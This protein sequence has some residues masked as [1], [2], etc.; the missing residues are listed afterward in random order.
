MGVLWP[1]SNHMEFDNNGV[2]ASGAKAYFYEAE[3]TTPKAVY[4]DGDETTPHE[5][6]LEADG[7][8]RWPA[9]YVPYGSY[10]VA[11]TTSGGT[12]IGST[13]DNIPNPE[14]FDESFEVDET[15]QLNTGDTWWSPLDS[16]RTGAVRLNGRTMGSASSGGTERAHADT[17]DLFTFL[18]NALANGQAAVSGGRGASAAAD[19]AANKTITLPDLRGAL[20]IGLTDMG[21]TD[22]GGLASAPVT[23]GAATTPGSVLGANTHALT[24]AQLATHLHSVSIASATESADHAHGVTITTS[25]DGGHTPTIN[26]SDT[27]T[28]ITG[29]SF[30]GSAGG[31]KQSTAGG[32]AWGE[33]HQTT[34]T[35]NSG[36]ISA[37]ANAV[38]AHTHT[39]SGA[40]SG[41]SVP[42]QHLVSGNT[43]NNGSGTAHNIVSKV[44]TGTWFIKLTIPLFA[45]IQMVEVL[46]CVG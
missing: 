28:W 32:S 33:G 8:G 3:T 40:T 31:A 43:G 38:A 12:A 29:A 44:I 42:H 15:A 1:S 16:T 14:P 7:N 46:R 26:V 45:S 34:V 2:R 39:V 27:R 30:V 41:A 13:I 6:P 24:T 21:N 4:E 23:S 10:K 17:E 37:T 19:F 36:S 22:S 18:W 25:S 9:V 11:I 35:V 20:P 5:F